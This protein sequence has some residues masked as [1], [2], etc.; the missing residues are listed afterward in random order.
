MTRVELHTLETVSAAS[1]PV[2]ERVIDAS[3]GVGTLNLWAAMAEAPATLDAYMAIRESIEAH[4]TFDP[5]LRSAIALAAAAATGGT[6]STAINRRIA[7]RA[8]Q[9]PEQIEAVRSATVDDPRLRSL[10]EVAR[11]AAADRGVIA[12]AT[13]GAAIDA[14]WTTAELVEVFAIVALTWFVDG[15]A[16]FA[17]V[18]LDVPPRE[19]T[20]AGTRST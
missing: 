16:A 2:L 4:A 19:L 1:R 17:Q 5:A 13:W 14:G 20:G 3:P 12:D 10:L 8:G 11:E 15:F 18:P 6:Y 9:S 7:A